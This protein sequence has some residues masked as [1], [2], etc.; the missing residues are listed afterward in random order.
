MA[1]IETGEEM[2]SPPQ[3][4]QNSKF[5]ETPI[6]EDRLKIINLCQKLK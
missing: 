5:Y 2:K 1:V 3:I 4:N 6:M